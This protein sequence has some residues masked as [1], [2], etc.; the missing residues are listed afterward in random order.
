MPAD[1]IPAST[2]TGEALATLAAAATDAAGRVAEAATNTAAA[3]AAAVAV[4]AAAQVAATA[5]AAKPSQDAKE[6]QRGTTVAR[7]ANEDAKNKLVEE[8]ERS[9][10]PTLEGT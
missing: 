6:I 4:A 7:A 3:A 8:L 5:A 2:E 9:K 10:R 1:T